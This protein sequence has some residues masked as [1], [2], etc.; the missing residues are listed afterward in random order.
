M[1]IQNIGCGGG[2]EETHAHA[3]Q[4]QRLKDR[5][6]VLLTKKRAWNNMCLKH[7]RRSFIKPNVQSASGYCM[8]QEISY[9]GIHPTLENVRGWCF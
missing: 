1:Y 7:F 4:H 6:A 3:K 5:F 9:Q 8:A 2:S